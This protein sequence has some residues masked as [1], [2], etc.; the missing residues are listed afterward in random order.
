MLLGA[1]AGFA[2]SK[3]SVMLSHTLQFAILL[4]M[5][6]NL[7][8]HALY[9]CWS[10]PRK[11]PPETHHER[12]GPAYMVGIA[13]TLIMVHPTYLVLRVGKQVDPLPYRKSLHTCT[14]IGYLLLLVGVLW[15]T[16]FCGKLRKLCRAAA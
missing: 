9:L 7:T 10:R 11:S 14:L 4:A 3:T 12:F 5:F 6:T 13:T 1:L 16:D 2:V 15:A 8:Q